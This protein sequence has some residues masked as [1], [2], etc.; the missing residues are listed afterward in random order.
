MQLDKVVLLRFF[1]VGV[2]YIFKMVKSFINLQIILDCKVLRVLRIQPVLLC[3]A[4][5]IAR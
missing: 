1:F 3:M 2:G 5:H 4:H